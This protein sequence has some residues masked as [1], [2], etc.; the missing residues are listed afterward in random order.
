MYETHKFCFG[1]AFPVL[2]Q[3]SQCWCSLLQCWPSFLSVGT[4]FPVL[5][6][7]S[8]GTQSLQTKIA[9]ATAFQILAM[10]KRSK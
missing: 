8:T 5:A 2:A 10:D 3:L 4:A 7:Y 9:V 6:F 1:A